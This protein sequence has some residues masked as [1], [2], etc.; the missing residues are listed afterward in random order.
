M[1][2]GVLG[3]QHELFRAGSDQR[4][5]AHSL[6]LLNKFGLIAENDV[7]QAVREAASE[8]IAAVPEADWDALP[9]WFVSPVFNRVRARALG[10]A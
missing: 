10:A 6:K 4:W 7:N 8:V 1:A 2:V 3:T 5:P 9:R